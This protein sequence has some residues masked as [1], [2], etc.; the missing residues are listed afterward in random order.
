VAPDARD[1]VRTVAPDPSVVWTASGTAEAA[2]VAEGAA[3]A[4]GARSPRLMVAASVAAV[5]VRRHVVRRA[6]GEGWANFIVSLS[7]RTSSGQPFVD[8]GCF[9]LLLFKIICL[10]MNVRK[11][12]VKLRRNQRTPT[13]PA[14]PGL[15]SKAESP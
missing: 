1:P 5:S 7:V 3:T 8:S 2:K 4:T 14:N 11:M 6:R 10:I 9:Q 12:A 15:N 13:Q